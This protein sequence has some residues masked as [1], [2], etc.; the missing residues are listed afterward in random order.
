MFT[1]PSKK[2]HVWALLIFIGSFY[3]V[4]QPS[5]E[6]ERLVAF[7]KDLDLLT[8]NMFLRAYA[9]DRTEEV[10]LL[11]E[12]N[13]YI[14]KQAF[15]EQ[16]T[17]LMHAITGYGNQPET[18][19]LLIVRK[20]IET[21][22]NPNHMCL[23]NPYVGCS[24]LVL[25]TPLHAASEKNYAIIT[26]ILLLAGTN[27]NLTS[28][29]E[30]KTALHKLLEQVRKVCYIKEDGLR[31]TKMI[32][33]S[34]ITPQLVCAEQVASIKELLVAG[35]DPN[36]PACG[37][38]ETAKDVLE[39]LGIDHTL[40]KPNLTYKIRQ[41]AYQKYIQGDSSMLHLILGLDTKKLAS[42]QAMK[43][44]Q[45][46]ARTLDHAIHQ[47]RKFFKDVLD[48]PFWQKAGITFEKEQ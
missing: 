39:R 31:D 28:S 6:G 24:R 18:E 30:N 35:T 10:T 9:Q 34:E 36:M 1:E 44:M 40:Y 16:K 27:P 48:E 21:K 42:I 7:I 46:K 47:N 11:L 37:T 20:L 14:T 3:G 17:P 2:I 13:P 19:C 43:A 45:G 12:A 25:E 33:L 5:T 23:T 4:C 32:P 41:V 26:K 22:A 15:F 29:I 38:L 8:A